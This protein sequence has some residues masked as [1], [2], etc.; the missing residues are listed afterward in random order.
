MIRFSIA[1]AKTD[2]DIAACMAIRKAVFVVEQNVPLEL[3]LDEYDATGTHF[4]MRNEDG[5]AIATA[6]LLNKHGLAK[7]GRVAVVKEWR[8]RG[9]GL[10]LMRF[11]L[12][13]A[14]GSGFVEAILDS[15]T[16]AIS[17]YER[18]GFVAGSLDGHLPGLVAV[19]PQ[20]G[21]PILETQ[22][23]VG[24]VLE[25]RLGERLEF[26]RVFQRHHVVLRREFER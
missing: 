14:K 9:A 1:I 24:P 26:L 5:R 22:Q 2:A 25:G 8:G 17:F 15:Q 12:E 20:L 13:T 11:V 21:R 18:L 10:E 16:Y 6:R 7:I 4:L 23:P 3:E 19:L